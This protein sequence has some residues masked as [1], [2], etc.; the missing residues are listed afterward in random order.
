MFRTST[1][2]YFLADVAGVRPQVT[3]LAKIGYTRLPLASAT[4]LATWRMCFSLWVQHVVFFVAHVAIY[5]LTAR[6]EIININ[7]TPVRCTLRNSTPITSYCLTSPA[8]RSFIPEV[9]AFLPRVT[10]R[11]FGHCCAHI[12]HRTFIPL[13]MFARCN[14]IVA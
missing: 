10:E 5:I 13:S 4:V 8:Q 14:R 11:T 6:K 9:K 12:A 3:L 7:S 1:A 2:N